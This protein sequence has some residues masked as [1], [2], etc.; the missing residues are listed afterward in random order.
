L[1]TC[2]IEDIGTCLEADQFVFSIQ[3]KADNL[4]GCFDAMA[5][6]AFNLPFCNLVVQTFL[7]FVGFVQ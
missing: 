2:S 4:L 3:G 5:L 1:E 6:Q 7:E